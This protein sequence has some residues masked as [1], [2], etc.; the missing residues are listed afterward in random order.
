MST[1]REV[2][3]LGSETVAGVNSRFAGVPDE[4]IL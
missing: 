2:D 4:K 1:F 3:N